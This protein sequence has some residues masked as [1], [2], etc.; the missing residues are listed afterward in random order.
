MTTVDAWRGTVRTIRWSPVLA[1]PLATCVAILALRAGGGPAPP[2]LTLVGTTGLAF[3]AMVVAFLVDDVTSEAAPATPVGARDRLLTRAAF[4]VPVVAAGWLLVLAFHHVVLAPVAS[5]EVAAQARWAI[6]VAFGAVGFAS[7]AGAGRA[8]SSPGAVG[9]AAMA[10]VGV[11]SQA[12][13][14]PW[15]EALPA[16][17]VLC[18]GTALFAALSAAMATKEPAR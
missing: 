9:V 12:S 7:L 18:A 5:A 6:G 13:L 11:A 17:E 16:S 4:V 8:F 1:T 15:M 10:C 3:T 14:T 2:G